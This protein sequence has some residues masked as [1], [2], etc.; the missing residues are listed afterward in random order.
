MP[1]RARPV[2]RHFVQ[3]DLSLSRDERELRFAEHD[4]TMTAASVCFRQR[5]RCDKILKLL[6]PTDIDKRR[7]SGSG[8]STLLRAL[9]GIWPFARGSI[10]LPQR[11]MFL[12]QRPDMPVGTLRHAVVYPAG[13]DDVA[14]RDV[15]AAL[16]AVGLEQL[17]DQLDAIDDWALRLS[18]GEQ[19]RLALAR[20]LIVKPAWLFLDEALSAVDESSAAALSPRTTD[21]MPAPRRSPSGRHLLPKTSGER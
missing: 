13:P 21:T 3:H 20:V 11:C 4:C 10:A 17:A 9:A 1:K 18:G 6:Y 16:V 15:N 12:P 5:C 8:K 19:Q 2:L 7:P 14:D